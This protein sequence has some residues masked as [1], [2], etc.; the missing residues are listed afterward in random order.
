[1]ERLNSFLKPI[2]WRNTKDDVANELQLPEQKEK[3]VK[4]L[5]FSAVESTFYRK[6]HEE[7]SVRLFLPFYS[8]SFF[9]L[10]F[11]FLQFFFDYSIYSIIIRLFF[12]FFFKFIIVINIIGQGKDSV[13]EFFEERLPSD[14]EAQVGEDSPPPSPSPSGLLPSPGHYY[15]IVIHCLSLFFTCILHN[16]YLFIL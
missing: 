6:Q 3:E 12:F 10:F 4:L 13:E 9:F 11:C 15:Y 1:M 14:G 8:C 7:C 5:R 16:Y 2:M